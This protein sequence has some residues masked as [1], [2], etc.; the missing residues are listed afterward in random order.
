MKKILFTSF[1]LLSV[2][3]CKKEVTYCWD[4]SAT[5]YN[6]TYTNDIFCGENITDVERY[7]ERV[8]GFYNGGCTN[9]ECKLIDK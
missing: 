9:I 6:K 4:C 3:S 2:F 8:Y 7:K 1:L 5:I